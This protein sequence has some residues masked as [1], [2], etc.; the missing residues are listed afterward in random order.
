L[1]YKVVWIYALQKIQTIR[2]L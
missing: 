1:Y 2:I